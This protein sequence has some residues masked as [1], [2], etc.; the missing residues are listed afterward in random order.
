MS[1]E[2]TV[3]T[4][5]ELEALSPTDRWNL[6]EVLGAAQET[7]REFNDDELRRWVEVEGK[8]QRE[9]AEMVGRSPGRIAQR[10]SRLGLV[11]HD[12]RGG[13]RLL[14]PKQNPPD[15]DDDAEVVEGEVSE[16]VLDPGPRVKCPTCGHMVKPDDIGTW[17]E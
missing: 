13:S 12:N 10:A 11:P 7:L 1:T 9:I 16:A 5:R 6:E 2:L 15:D 4:A 17:R 14:S 3:P 8:T